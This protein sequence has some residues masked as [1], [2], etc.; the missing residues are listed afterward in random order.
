MTEARPWPNNAGRARDEAV[1]K[2]RH[3][4]NALQPVLDGEQMT[5]LELLRRIAYALTDLHTI[6]TLL[7]GAGAP[8]RKA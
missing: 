8:E 7:V 2:A 4:Q 6:E 1:Y 3:G 5:Q